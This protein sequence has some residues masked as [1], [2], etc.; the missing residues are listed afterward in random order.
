MPRYRTLGGGCV[1]A[2]PREAIAATDPVMTA[3][4]DRFAGA[5]GRFL[6]DMLWFAD[7]FGSLPR[8]RNDKVPFVFG[9]CVVLND[10]VTDQ[11]VVQPEPPIVQCSQVADDDTINFSECF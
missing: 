3:I 10:V 8:N 1:R 7:T 9:N 6:G 4:L 11:S 2:A 5:M